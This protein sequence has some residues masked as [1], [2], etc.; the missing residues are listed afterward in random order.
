MELETFSWSPRVDPQ[1][2]IQHRTLSVQ[3]GDGYV[4]EA[5]DGINPESQSWPLQFVGREPY[6]QPILAFVRR[7]QGYRKFLWTPP[8]GEQGMY[9]ARDIRLRAMGGGMYTLSFTMKQ[10]F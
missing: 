7:H 5:A 2:E 3:L 4:Q 1:G 8:M 10:A 9:K 6:V